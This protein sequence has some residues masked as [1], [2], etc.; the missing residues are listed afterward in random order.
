MTDDRDAITRIERTLRRELAPIHLDVTDESDRHAG[1]AGAI[2]GKVTHVHILVVSDAFQGL[3]RLERHRRI[4]AL[5]AGEIAAGLHALSIETLT[6]EE[7]VRA[8]ALPQ[9]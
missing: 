1:H 3:S 4:N 5:L 8:P 6:P 2:P 7:T 9:G